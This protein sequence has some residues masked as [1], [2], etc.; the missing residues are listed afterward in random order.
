MK[1]GCLAG[2]N[3]ILINTKYRIS[4]NSSKVVK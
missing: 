2:M 4:S 1:G 3:E